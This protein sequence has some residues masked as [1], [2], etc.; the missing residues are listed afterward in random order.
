M[1][2]GGSLTG[3]QPSPAALP[4]P[5]RPPRSPPLPPPSPLAAGVLA[6]SKDKQRKFQETVELQVGLK[7]YDP[8][9]DKRFSGS[10]KLPFCPRPQMK[11]GAPGRGGCCAR[12]W[13]ARLPLCRPNARRHRCGMGLLL[14]RSIISPVHKSIAQLNPP[15]ALAPPPACLPGAR[16]ACWVTTS[17]AR[18][19]R[20]WAWMP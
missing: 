10:V 13:L 4:P 15:P 14:T 20:P 11:V 8:Q 2:T 17:I 5:P 3:R 18:R 9:K 19:P 1:G 12:L 7:N 16:C 6:G